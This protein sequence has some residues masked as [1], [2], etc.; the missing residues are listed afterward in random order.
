[1]NPCANAA[2]QHKSEAEGSGI[3]S[4]KLVMGSRE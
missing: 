4:K 1:V 3:E 2:V